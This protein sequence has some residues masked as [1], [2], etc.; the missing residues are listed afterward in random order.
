MRPRWW[1]GPRSSRA[2]RPLNGFPRWNIK[3]SSHFL[4]SMV[5]VSHHGGSWCWNLCQNFLNTEW[6]LYLVGQT[7]HVDFLSFP[8]QI[9]E[10]KLGDD[11]SS[12]EHLRQLSR[13]LMLRV[14]T[15]PIK[16]QK[17]LVLSISC[18]F[19][20]TSIED[21]MLHSPQ[22]SYLQVQSCLPF[23]QILSNHRPQESSD[24]EH[25]IQMHR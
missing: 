13:F 4:Y 6:L 11:M 14:N 10:L 12:N 23:V 5:F 24:D 8:S 21:L 7:Q 25:R 1:A 19:K 9:H 17:L 16:L 3:R 18:C 22:S 15:V 20:L 2:G